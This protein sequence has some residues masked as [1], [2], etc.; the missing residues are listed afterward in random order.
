MFRAV[1][2]EQEPD[3]SPRR[4]RLGCVLYETGGREGAKNLNPR[5]F[6][7]ILYSKE[8]FHGN[9][10]NR[11]ANAARPVD[12]PPAKVANRGGQN[13]DRK[14]APFAGTGGPGAGTRGPRNLWRLRALRRDRGAG[15]PVCRSHDA[16]LPGLRSE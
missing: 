14:P 10:G 4:W 9:P 13:P 7:T 16:A 6:E 12:G 5:A 2:L 15:T 1:L 8:L 3:G 11:S